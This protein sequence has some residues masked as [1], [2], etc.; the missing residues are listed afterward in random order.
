MARK[1]RKPKVLPKGVRCRELAD[2]SLLFDRRVYF[3]DG[4]QRY[5]SGSTLEELAHAYAKKL[6]ER[7]KAGSV[8]LKKTE[9]P[10]YM[11]VGDLA[12]LWMSDHVAKLADKTDDYYRVALKYRVAP[13]LYRTTVSKLTRRMVNKWIV[14]LMK[15]QS[16]G[17]DGELLWNADGTMK[18]AH[19]N[20]NVNAALATLK[21]MFGWAI[22]EDILTENPCYKIKMLPV[23]SRGTEIYTPSQ[24]LTMCE[25]IWN[26]R[27]AQTRIGRGA[28]EIERAIRLAT[29]DQ[30]MVLLLACTGLRVSEMAGL[31][32]RDYDDGR[33]YNSSG[34]LVREKP[35]G[36]LHVRQ[37][38]YE[39]RNGITGPTKGKRHRTVPV[40]PGLRAALDWYLAL[41][42][43]REPN[44]LLFPGMRARDP[45]QWRHVAINRWRTTTFTPAAIATGLPQ[46]VP[47]D[48]RHT[49]ATM[50]IEFSNGRV[51]T[52]R[53]AKWLGHTDTK[54]IDDLYGHVYDEIADGLLDGV[55]EALFGP[56]GSAALA[57]GAATPELSELAGDEFAA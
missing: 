55:N 50:M 41:L 16:V 3:P 49:F 12:D 28:M 21:A 48:L 32:R 22:E 38:L 19:S 20:R 34:E 23:D 2:G 15:E 18:R 26:L 51:P 5:A 9:D 57:M 45:K 30:T 13:H 47:H 56:D 52:L 46:A 17:G 11:T 10:R 31:R 54:L 6:K 4:S 29:R 42:P 37:Q 43:D 33:E 14:T 35:L 1:P 7:D 36:K 40:V 53:L 25:H 39:R 24:V 44:D 27:M 8:K